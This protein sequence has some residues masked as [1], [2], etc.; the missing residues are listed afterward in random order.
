[1]PPRTHH[2]P[3]SSRT[4]NPALDATVLSRLRIGARFELD[5]LFDD[6]DGKQLII[7]QSHITMQSAWQLIFEDH[8]LR[9]G[10]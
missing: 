2:W 5:G 4:K 9:V 7:L 3:S 8:Q 10:D 1:M 6:F